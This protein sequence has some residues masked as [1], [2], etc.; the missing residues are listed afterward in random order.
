MQRNEKLHY[1]I[2]TSCLYI[3]RTRILAV[4][5]IVE[6]TYNLLLWTSLHMIVLVSIVLP[7]DVMYPRTTC[8]V[9][10]FVTT[11]GNSIVS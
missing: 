6:N 2:L 4:V 10:T 7:S 5:H 11:N 8:D 3:L 1:I 9:V